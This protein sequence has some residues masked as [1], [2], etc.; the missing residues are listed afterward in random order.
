MPLWWPG[1]G[2]CVLL[3][4]CVRVAAQQQASLASCRQ[5]IQRRGD[6]A[7]H[8][9]VS[10]DVLQLFD[11][12]W[13]AIVDCLPAGGV[14]GIHAGLVVRPKAPL[15]LSKPLEIRPEEAE[16]VRDSEMVHAKC[17]E[18]GLFEIR[19]G[20]VRL[21]SLFLHKCK[22]RRAILLS[23]CAPS[24]SRNVTISDTTFHSGTSSDTESA[25]HVASSN[26]TLVLTGVDFV[27][28]VGGAVSMKRGS[29]LVATQSRFAGNI[30]VGKG[31]A[32]SVHGSG[33]FRADKCEF[34]RNVAQKGGA[35][36][37]KAASVT[38]LE[39]LA[40]YGNTAGK[41]GGAVHVEENS[42]VTATG[43][44]F[45]GNRAGEQGGAMCIV[46]GAE[47]A[48]GNDLGL[49]V[50]NI[51]ASN[52]S[53]NQAGNQG[54]AVF[55]LSPP[56][57]DDTS[58]VHI[59]ATNFS[60]NRAGQEI[61]EIGSSALVAA[62][63]GWGGAV[64]LGD[65]YADNTKDGKL[66]CRLIDS[67]M[68]SE[69]NAENGGALTAISVKLLSM[70]T[71]TFANNF[72]VKGGA[73]YMEAGGDSSPIKSR[74]PAHYLDGHRIVCTENLASYGGA[75]YLTVSPATAKLA[76]KGLSPFDIS[77]ND[78]VYGGET[79]N[80]DDVFLE[81]STFKSNVA[82]ACGGAVY[83]E[84]GRLGC[85]EC[86]FAKNKVVGR[87]QRLHGS[88]GALCLKKQS[89]VHGRGVRLTKNT[90]ANGGAIYA[91]ESLVDVV[92]GVVQSNKAMKGGGIYV[93][94]PFGTLFEHNVSARVWN[95]QLV[96]NRAEIGGGAYL[97]IEKGPITTAF[98]N[99]SNATTTA[100]SKQH[101]VNFLTVCGADP[102]Q[103][104][105]LFESTFMSFKHADFVQN[106]ASLTGGALFTNSPKA[107]D[108]CCGCAS[109]TDD[110]LFRTTDGL[111]SNNPCPDTWLTNSAGKKDGGNVLATAVAA[112]KACNASH[113]ASEAPSI[114]AGILDG[115]CVRDGGLLQ[116]F[117]HNSGTVLSRI[118][119][120]MF[121]AFNRTLV[122]PSDL[123]MQVTSDEN[124]VN[125][126]GERLLVGKGE[127]I[128]R[129]IFV[130]AEVDKKHNL[131]LTF[132]PPIFSNITIEVHVRACVPGE[133]QE[134]R[135]QRCNLCGDG[136]F[137]FNVTEQ[138]EI[139]PLLAECSDSL[140]IPTNGTW[141]ST[142]KSMQVHAC[143]L[144]KACNYDERTAWLSG[145]ASEAHREGR[146]LSYED[147]DQYRQCA[148]GYHG[149]LCG[150]CDS[151]HGKVRSGECQQCGPRAT[152]VLFTLL[153]AAW[154]TII[155]ALLMRNALISYKYY[156]ANAPPGPKHGLGPKHAVGPPVEVLRTTIVANHRESFQNSEMLASNQSIRSLVKG[157]SGLQGDD[158][159]YSNEIFKILINFLQVTGISIFVNVK[160]T[161]SVANC[162]GATDAMSSGGDGLFS[163][164]CALSGGHV[165]RSIQ[166]LF[167]GVLFPC[168]MA[169]GFIMYWAVRAVR[170][171]K[172]PR[173]FYTRWMVSILS[174][175]YVFY[176]DITRSVLTVFECISVD[177]DRKGPLGDAIA[178]SMYWV[179]D[180]DIECHEG[181][182]LT[183]LITIG[184]P[185]LAFVTV[186]MPLGILV[187][188]V[189]YQAKLHD[190]GF[191]DRYGFLYRSYRPECR[192]WEVVIM[193]RKATMAGVAVFAYSLGPE[194][195][196]TLGMGVLFLAIFVHLLKKPYVTE[197]PRL[198]RM[199]AL[200]IF[201]SFLVF[202]TG[203]IFNDSRTTEA[204]EIVVS[205]VL[206]LVL[207]AVPTYLLQQLVLEAY[208]TVDS[209]LAAN[210]I[211]VTKD[212]T[213]V[214][215]LWLL[216]RATT[217][218][219]MSK[220]RVPSRKRRRKE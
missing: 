56:E 155:T 67:C 153:V 92:D 196:N 13:Q 112:V 39:S 194:L 212:D 177:S 207:V 138:C 18:K 129:Q 98:Q 58:Y 104:R 169:L 162:L 181:I 40:F 16:G 211:S 219:A 164:E 204:G 157:G 95:T 137:S 20:G 19:S 68:F 121:N 115:S 159:N 191:L 62:R 77:N 187:I 101:A 31:G 43:C 52:F 134:H 105:A 146:R 118:T 99:C 60:R 71:A 200:S 184:V 37:A 154:L 205:A 209:Q 14:L 4:L 15:I 89:T 46:A 54:G 22:A 180:T 25:V 173:Y 87:S 189:K 110:D 50:L 202:F 103:E 106:N 145:N 32:V 119:V 114:D 83:Q 185:F 85:K 28:N 175:M 214:K 48:I 80:E 81:D 133:V 150:A 2:L 152:N 139:C 168:A 215:K 47:H 82:L 163:I 151:T 69:N 125:L 84:R 172:P 188:L 132:T 182:H 199:E 131:T 38:R 170:R 61:F 12:D 176:L 213:A 21:S 120:Q 74:P 49:Y 7:N 8:I 178:R 206:I 216:A 210:K 17:P 147:D 100:A 44:Q 148:R 5:I 142:S 171:K 33:A 179:A 165:P 9:Q 186:G 26:C 217:N 218:D 90:A 144:S 135:K 174:V 29:T 161:E 70:D 127:V 141:H 76:R 156:G 3:H 11:K 24:P 73:M 183:L 96:D 136:R 66:L 45:E 198:N 86:N 166:A 10:E 78:E 41:Y 113:N 34:E 51:S 126:S 122:G 193:L 130:Q 203:I 57:R 160:W 117:G 124:T 88:G 93:E 208:K 123:V 158:R 190:R 1:V 195:Q 149:V 197:G 111:K 167:L 192:Y 53:E 201:A 220:V 107:I 109:A 55:A 65:D 36:W 97:F 42:N 64:Y 27:D 91:E 72:A 6:T 23:D 75:L 140:L 116:V 102:Q 79:N 94:I 143:I 35:V 128:L 108:V 30:R 59:S 63:S